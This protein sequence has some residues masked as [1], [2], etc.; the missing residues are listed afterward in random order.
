MPD[1]IS[2]ARSSQFRVF[3]QEAGSSPVNPYV[4]VGCLNL[5]GFQQDLGTGDPIYCPSSE[6]RGAYD[7]VD[8]TAPPPA[9]PTTDFTQHMSRDLQD[10]WWDLRRRRCAFNMAVAGSNCAA[11]DDLND[12]QSKILVK[13]AR[14]TA[15]NTGAFNTSDADAA[16]DLTGSLQLGGFDRFL[17]MTFG[18]KA[19]TSTFSEVIDGIF[20]DKIQCGDCGDP[21]NGAQKMYVL[22]STIAA[23]PALSSQIVHTKNGGST[24]VTDDITTLAT[25]AGSALANVGTRIVVVSQTDL[26]HHYKQQST[27]DAGTSG[28]WSRVTSG[29]VTAKGPNAIWS[30]S[31]SETYVA[32]QGGY[33]YF[34]ANPATAVTVLTDGSVTVQNLNDIRGKGRSIVAVGASNAVILSENGGATWSLVTGPAVGVALNTVEVVNASTWWIGTATGKVYYT[35]NKGVTW[36]ENT[37]DSAITVV[38]SIRFVDELVGYMAVET[39]GTPRIY[40]TSDNGYSWHYDGS[41]VAGVPTTATRYNFVIPA[42]NNYNV[43]L[44]GG[45]KSVGTDGIISMGVG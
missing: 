24:W 28:S 11:P 45:L 15:F 27:I 5:G 17:P 20:A 19:D 4:Y 32:A 38:D 12:F 14:M 2:L 31:P 37:P 34:M 6:V 44:A 23:S 42:A 36:T 1:D 7:I 26:A 10:F 25:K 8:T 21:S 30:K 39:S 18:E 16:I 9:L 43:V 33:V 3:V 13:A 41:Y 35:T 40:R 22:T 29:Y